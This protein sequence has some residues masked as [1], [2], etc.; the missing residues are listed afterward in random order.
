MPR[1]DPP[2]AAAEAAVAAAFAEVA[3]LEA[4]LS[5]YKPDSEVSRVNAAAGGPAVAVSAEVLDLVRRAVLVCEATD[6]LLDITFLPLG[7]LWDFSRVPFVAPDEAAVA[8]ARALV[9]CRAIEIDPDASTLRLPRDGMGLGLGAIAPG[10]AVDR[11]SALLT[12]AGFPDHL[13]NGGGEVLARG[14]KADGPWVVGIRHPRGGRGDLMGRMPLRDA[15][16][17]TAGDYERM[18]VVDGQRVHHILDPRTGRPARGLT[19]V[20]VLDAS[21]ERADA[22]DT[23]L[24]VAGSDD[25]PALMQRLGIEALLVREDGTWQATRGF[26]A[27]AEIDGEGD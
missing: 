9:D 10:F 11:A 21:A 14:A 15:A 20:S 3:R 6:G 19:S 7:D 18:T 24:L 17:T 25:A 8:R 13:V 22:L 27:R 1:P 23:A 16:L 2:E 12:G 5:T 26:T 4:L